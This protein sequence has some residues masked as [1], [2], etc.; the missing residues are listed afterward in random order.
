METTNL[1]TF[2]FSKM[3]Y[4]DYEKADKLCLKLSKSRLKIFDY[5][6][7][8][9]VALYR[10]SILTITYLATKC[11]R[12]DFNIE[13]FFK[14]LQAEITDERFKTEKF[15]TYD[16][17]IEE[18]LKVDS[19]L[20]FMNQYYQDYLEFMP[21][22]AF[23]FFLEAW[24]SVAKH[25]GIEF[26]KTAIEAL[27]KQLNKKKE[28]KIEEQIDYMRD[29]K[30]MKPFLE[31]VEKIWKEYFPDWRFGQLMENFARANDGV[32]HLEE[33]EFLIGLKAFSVGEDINDAVI[34]HFEQQ[35]K[36]RIERERHFVGEGNLRRRKLQ[37]YIN[38]TKK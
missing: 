18:A 28:P 23:E 11:N 24:E 5:P 30:R 38:D 4:Y 12:E 1:E 6:K 26:D 34:A 32:F 36:E 22:N 37:D 3:G 10:F 14:L 15:T 7:E 19:T 21:D 2:L 27:W 16:I 29:P 13:C 35:K 31:E 25:Y 9:R 33:T 8:T 17:V 20:F